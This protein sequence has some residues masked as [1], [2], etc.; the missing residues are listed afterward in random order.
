MVNKKIL[1][2]IFFLAFLIISVA[3]L[4]HYGPNWDEPAHFGRGQAILHYFLTGKKDFQDLP[5]EGDQQRSLYQTDGYSYAYFENNF[6][7]RS[8]TGQILIGGGHP[9]LSD[10]FAAIFNL[11]F[12]QKLRILGD[13]EAYHF[14]SVFL[15]A[16]L[17]G[18][19]VYFTSN[20]YG[21]F[22][23]LIAGLSLFLYPLFLGESRFNIKDIPQAVFFG[24]SIIFFYQGVIKNRVRW[25]FLAALFFS[26]ALA[27]KLNIIFLPLIL[28]PWLAIRLLFRFYPSK[29]II[30]SSLIF[31]PLLGGLIFFVSFPFLWPEPIAYLGDILKYYQNIGSTTS[32]DPRFLTVFRLNT[33]AWQWL[34]YTTPVVILGLSLTG[35][36]YVLKSGFKEKEKTSFLILFWFLVP[37]L[38]VT[39]PNASIYGGLRQIMEYI[40]AMAILAGIGAKYILELANKVKLKQNFGQVLLLTAFL[41]IILRLAS[42]YPNENLFF[43]WLIGGLKGAKE[44]N[45]PGWGNSLGSTYRQGVKWLNEHAEKGARVALIYELKS[46]IPQ[47]DLRSDIIYDNHIRSAIKKEGEYVIGVTHQGTAENSYHRKYLER[48]LEPVYE[49]KVDS[50]AVL[51]IWKNDLSYTKSEYAKEEEKIRTFSVDKEGRHLLID[52]K[53]RQRIT[54]LEMQYNPNNCTLPTD[55]FFEISPDGDFWERLPGDFQVFPLASWFTPQPEKGKLQFLFAADEARFIKIVTDDK[56]SCLLLKPVNLNVWRI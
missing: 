13:I 43:N 51:K 42:L 38:R 45:L 32:F 22:A 39:R 24:L 18:I 47:A 48:F 15:A 2:L 34:I 37:L 49:V 44:R 12:Y 40:P 52:L 26:F 3:S 50:V 56:N 16:V 6:L 8:G 33:Y 1:S 28:L 41:P 53:E 30:L 17:V 31:F 11:I 10:I 29:K 19:V 55:G 54:K 35:L 20:L 23:G 7:V 21:N 46:N 9:P 5:P 14:Y 4:R 36:F 25:I 27:T